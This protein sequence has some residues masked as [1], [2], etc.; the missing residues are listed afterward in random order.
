MP[1]SS[2][3]N[4]MFGFFLI[5]LLML[6]HVAVAFAS[7]ADSGDWHYTLRPRDTIQT[8]GSTLLLP[9]YSW[10]DLAHY[11]QVAQVD[12]LAPGSILK[13]PMQWLKHQPQPA[14]VLSV[15]GTVLIK[16]AGNEHFTRLSANENIHVG[17]EVATQ[18]G[19]LLIKFAD[20]SIL[21]LEEQSNLIFN[22]LSSFGS[23][24]MVDTRMRLNKGSISTDV[25]PLKKGSRFEISTPSAVAAV[26]GTEFRLD[27]A[28]DETRVEVVEGKVA[29]SHEHGEVLV[30][31]GQ[32]AKVRKGSPTVEQRYL[33]PAPKPLFAE[34]TLTDLPATL[35]WKPDA[36]AKSYRY[37]LNQA[38]DQGPRIETQMLSSP[39]VELGQL[40]SGTYSVSMRAVDAQ[41]Y[42]GLDAKTSLQIEL[43]E[44]I[45][46]LSEPADGSIITSLRPEFSW[47]LSDSSANG[48][49]DLARDPAFS[50]MIFQGAF[51]AVGRQ[52][53]NLE[54]EPGSYYWRVTAMNEEA[55]ETFSATRSVTLRGTLDETRV[56]SVNYLDNQ[57]G[58]FWNAVENTQG[59]VLQVSDQ[60]D[61]SNILKEETLGKPNAHLRLNPGKY[62]YARVKGV[63]SELYHSEFGPIKELY[64]DAKK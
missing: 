15:Q 51:T 34:S 39:E 27:V 17:D 23:T 48:R 1:R 43:D 45:A 33:V 40:K 59:Y 55:V 60:P 24:G 5:A 30:H 47:F 46:N 56:L 42:A 16:R 21:R 29:V 14:T 54:L 19:T 4:T 37:E 28:P 10:S 7:E 38:T 2:M 57:V 12:K 3:L 44:I 64:V 31:A 50:R 53:P 8:V 32:G 58:L 49:L 36:R 41:G 62:Y 9:R 13:I 61:F 20:A 6:G 18:K 63:A 22:R 26:R 25:T 35:N 11:N 52:A